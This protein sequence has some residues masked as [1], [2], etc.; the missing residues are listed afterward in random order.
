LRPERVAESHVVN[1]EIER[2][3]GGTD[4]HGKPRH[5]GIGGL[6]A[7]GEEEDGQRRRDE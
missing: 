1:G 4:E 2:L 6:F 5:D 7:L 3:G